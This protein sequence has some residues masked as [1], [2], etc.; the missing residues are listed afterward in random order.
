[1]ITGCD[2]NGVATMSLPSKVEALTTE[3]FTVTLSGSSTMTL[4]GSSLIT[5]PISSTSIS[6]ELASDVG[7]LQGYSI[8]GPLIQLNHKSSDLPSTATDLAPISPAPNPSTTSHQASPSLATGAK[9]AIR[10]LVPITVLALV[11]LLVTF[12]R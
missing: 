7:G 11:A 12:L 6:T 10:V 9:V 4:P 2:D 3:L 8:F 5:F 1:M